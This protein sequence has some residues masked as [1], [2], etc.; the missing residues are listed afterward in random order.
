MVSSYFQALGKAF[1]SLSIIIL[2]NA[3]LF[4]PAVVL[5]NWLWGLPGIMAAQPL[6]EFLLA[7]T[8]LVLYA[9][10]LRTARHSTDAV[11]QQD[12]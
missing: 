10:E 11:I 3:V 8:C 6:V 1:H 9:L 4:I 7:G 5:L 12:I 2:R